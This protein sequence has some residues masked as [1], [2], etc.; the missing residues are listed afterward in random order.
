MPGPVTVFRSRT[1][2]EKARSGRTL[3]ARE[4]ICWDDMVSDP[5]FDNYVSAWR[6]LQ[7]RLGQLGL[8]MGTTLQGVTADMPGT[9]SEQI[10]SLLRAHEKIFQEHREQATRFVAYLRQLE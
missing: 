9:T 10:Q 8:E 1:E 3:F 2:S 5:D 6:D 7:E 4:S